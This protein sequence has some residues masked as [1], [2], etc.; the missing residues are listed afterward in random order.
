MLIILSFFIHHE[1]RITQEQNRQ[2]IMQNDSILSVNIILYDSVAQIRKS[3]LAEQSSIIPTK[4][5]AK[6]GRAGGTK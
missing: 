2:L 4:R 5:E 6:L 3:V 1:K